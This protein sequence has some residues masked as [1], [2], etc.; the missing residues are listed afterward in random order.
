MDEALTERQKR[1]KKEKFIYRDRKTAWIFLLPAIILLFV[2]A[3]IPLVMALVRSV[4]DYVSG[5]FVGFDNF[6]YILKTP[7]FMKSFLNVVMFTGIILV[8]QITLSFLFPHVLI[9]ISR[10]LTNVIKVIIYIP[11]LI[12]GVVASIIYAFILNYGGGLITSILISLDVDPIAFMTEGYWPILCVILPSFWLAFGYNTLVMHAGL[13]NV[14]SSYY[15]AADLDG[16]NFF[17]KLFYVTIPN[18]RNTFILIAVNTITGTLQM[19][20]IPMLITGGGPLNMTMTPA[21]YLFNTFR[22]VGRPLN[23]TIAGALLVMVVIVIINVI[24][25]RLIKTDRMETE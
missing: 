1:I 21:L 15:E 18:M 6:D 7:T 19:L 17:Q 8:L 16:A 11:C 2:F 10:K 24:A 14:P 25:F 23:V 20:E 12:S 9:A 22:D 13:I 4:T 5:E 3:Y